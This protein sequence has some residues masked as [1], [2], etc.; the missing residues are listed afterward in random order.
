VLSSTIFIPNKDKVFSLNLVLKYVSSC[1]I[2]VVKCRTG[3]HQ[4]GV[5]CTGPISPNHHIKHTWEQST[6]RVNRNNLLFWKFVHHI[7]FQRGTTFWKP[8]LFQFSGKEAFNL[9]DTLHQAILSQW[10]T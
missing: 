10:T 8:A 5:L 2:H 6:T 7:L 1:Q 3:L 9:V 4:T